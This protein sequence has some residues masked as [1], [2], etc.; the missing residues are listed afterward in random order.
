M[1][2]RSREGQPPAVEVPKTPE[3]IEHEARE[4]VKDEIVEAYVQQGHDRAAM[5][6]SDAKITPEEREELRK[7]SFV[8]A[9][10]TARVT[11]ARILSDMFKLGDLRELLQTPEVRAAALKGV[12]FALSNGYAQKAQ[13]AIAESGLRAEEITT[14]EFKDLAEKAALRSLLNGSVGAFDIWVGE[15]KLSPDFVSSAP[16]K[17]IAHRAIRTFA[18]KSPH[19]AADIQKYFEISAEELATEQA[20]LETLAGVIVMMN[21]AKGKLVPPEQVNLGLISKADAESALV[22]RFGDKF[23]QQQFNEI[24]RVIE[25]AHRVDPVE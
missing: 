21:L 15:F 6:A 3:Q 16:V 13:I 25:S 4:K 18:T 20:K 9:L 7:Q 10:S 5:M 1:S 17:E 19:I 23:D 2:E 8:L 24:W 11:S 22:R 12:V 14:P